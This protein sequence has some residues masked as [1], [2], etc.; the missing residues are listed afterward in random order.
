MVD[1]ESIRNVKDIVIGLRKLRFILTEKEKDKYIALRREISNIE[2]S[3]LLYKYNLD[4]SEED[5]LIELSI[6]LAAKYGK[7]GPEYA[8]DLIK[9]IKVLREGEFYFSIT[10]DDRI[11]HIGNN[12][13]HIVDTE[14]DIY[15]GLYKYYKDRGIFE[16]ILAHSFEP[17]HFGV[18][19]Y[20]NAEKACRVELIL[21]LGKT[22]NG[23][24]TLV[25]IKSHSRFVFSRVKPNIGAYVYSIG[26]PIPQEVKELI[27]I[28]LIKIT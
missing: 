26:N 23:E 21:I 15:K 3:G 6:K 19:R 1:I 7:K 22:S 18:V 2:S 8:E 17:G 11:E 28:G 10:P 24:P 16:L 4:K 14:D 13:Y 5:L 27:K 20:E 25:N 12:I 9:I